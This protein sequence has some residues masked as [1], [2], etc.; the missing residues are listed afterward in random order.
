MT[1]ILKLGHL[2]TPL[3][4]LVVALLLAS[5]CSGGSDQTTMERELQEAVS[6]DLVPVR[7]GA[8]DCPK[9][10][11]KS[12]E[13]VFACQT[14]VQ[15][16]Y[17]EIQVRMLDAQGRYDYKLKHVALQVIRTEAALADQ[18]SIDVGF[19]V[20]ADC[21]DEEYIVA[22][23][24]GTFSCYAKTIDGSGQ[25]KVEVRVEDVDKTLTW[26]LLTD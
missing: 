13:S 22:L 21:G 25:R 1:R 10:V 11:S 15:G 24:G 23:V 6:N 7:I 4:V 8:V 5:A 3:T 18:I 2:K 9:D 20:A 12:P 16:N 19:D 14:E 17:F 26:F